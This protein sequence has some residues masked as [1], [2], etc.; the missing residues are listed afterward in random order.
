MQ[1]SLSS[2][3]LKF[4]LVNIKS[5]FQTLLGP[6]NI[7]KLHTHLPQSDRVFKE[8]KDGCPSPTITTLMCTIRRSSQKVKGRSAL[9]HCDKTLYRIVTTTKRRCTIRYWYIHQSARLNI[10]ILHSA[11]WLQH[12]KDTSPNKWKSLKNG[13]KQQVIDCKFSKLRMLMNCHIFVIVVQIHIIWLMSL[14]IAIN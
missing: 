7:I 2:T 8:L 14:Q 11:S 12:S 4:T 9:L 3:F 1:C 6:Q 10:I 5:I 13:I